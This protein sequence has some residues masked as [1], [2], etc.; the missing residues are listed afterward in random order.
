MYRKFPCKNHEQIV[1]LYRPR[2][3]GDED[4]P[5]HSVQENI[6]RNVSPSD[7]LFRGRT[8]GAQQQYDDLIVNTTNLPC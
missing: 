5:V 8:S 4:V 3:D 2:F 6:N 1:V 7:R